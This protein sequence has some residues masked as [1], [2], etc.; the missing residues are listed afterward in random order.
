MDFKKFKTFILDLDGTL[1]NWEELLPGSKELIEKL[2]E[3]KKQV[4]FVTNNTMVRR[5]ELREKLVNFGIECEENQIISSSLAIEEYLKIKGGK[6]FVIGDG[7]KEDLIEGGIE[8]REDEN[9]DYVVVG[10]DTK[11]NFQKLVI[12]VKAVKKNGAAILAS[13]M[14]R[15]FVFGKEILPGTGSIVNAIE[16]SCNKRAKLLG[17]PSDVMCQLVQLFVQS[18][19]KDTVV[20]GDEVKADIG[21]GKKCGYF[22]VLVRTGVDK[23]VEE[24]EEFKPDLI[25]NSL[26]EVKI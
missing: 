5:K 6:A 3:E 2:K 26:T 10:H 22:S 9:V 24:F 25:L 1:W 15:A 11:F 13:A 21:L 19:R 14:G 18:P 17:K 12:A 20:F 4:L 8:I 16:Y 7:L 23:E